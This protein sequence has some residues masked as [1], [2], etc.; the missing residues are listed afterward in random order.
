MF[1]DSSSSLQILL[2]ILN[3]ESSSV[4]DQGYFS[5]ILSAQWTTLSIWL[6][7]AMFFTTSFF[8][9][10]ERFVILL[11]LGVVIKRVVSDNMFSITVAFVFKAAW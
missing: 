7:L 2:L 11:I 9:L 4:L 8:F 10:I 6:L 3:Y 5:L 1:L